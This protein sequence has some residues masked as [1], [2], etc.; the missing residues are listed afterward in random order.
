MRLDPI[1]LSETE[2]FPSEWHDCDHLHIGSTVRTASDPSFFIILS[3]LFKLVSN[4]LNCHFKFFLF[5]EIRSLEPYQANPNVIA[6][7]PSLT[8]FSHWTHPREQKS[9]S[10]NGCFPTWVNHKFLQKPIDLIT[11]RETSSLPI[12]TPANF[13]SKISQ[14]ELDPC[15]LPRFSVDFLRRQLS[16]PR[17]TLITRTH[18]R[19]NHSLRHPTTTMTVRFI[20]LPS[21]SK[22]GLSR[23]GRDQPTVNR[24]RVDLHQLKTIIR[25]LSGT[26]W[27]RTE[28]KKCTSRGEK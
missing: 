5:S 28:G 17:R 14:L 4:K 7:P 19:E 3:S 12:P 2:I 26:L 6:M 13:S 25:S 10:R 20:S 22:P 8:L 1:M 18:T 16:A 23:S 27:G 24:Y 11:S 21:G 9:P 15:L